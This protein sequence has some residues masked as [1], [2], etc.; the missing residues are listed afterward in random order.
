[1]SK[2]NPGLHKIKVNTWGTKDKTSNGLDNFVEQEL[3]GGNVGHASIEMMLPVTEETKKLIETYCKEETFEEFKAHLPLKAQQKLTFEQYMEQAEDRIP[4][5]LVET[6]VPLALYNDDGELEVSKKK[7]SQTSYYKIDF[8]FWPGEDGFYLSN[9]EEDMIDEREGHH[10]EYSERA[11]EYLQPEERIH[12]GKIGSQSMTYAPSVIAHQRN[13]SD[14]DFKE[15]ERATEAQKIKD[16]LSSSGL[17]IK[18]VKELKSLKIDGTLG[19]ICKNMGLQTAPIIKEFMEANPVQKGEKV[20]IEKFK[21]FFIEK[22]R[23]HISGLQRKR[24]ELK[25]HINK[26]GDVDEILGR[27]KHVTRG[28]PPDHTVELPFVTESSRGLN[29]EAMLK[30]MRELTNPDAAEF[31]LHTKNCSKTST[32]VLKAG[33]EH[34]PLLSRTLGEEALGAIGTPQQVIGNVERARNV[35]VTDKQNTLLTRIAN[36]DMLNQAM[37]GFI[38]E[39]MKEDLTRGQKAKAIAGIIGVGILKAPEALI[40]AVINPSQSM[41]DLASGVGTV[42]KHANSLPLKIG[43]GILSAIPMVFLAPF[44]LVEKGLQAMA[45]PFNA[46]SRW[47]D[48]KPLSSKLDDQITVPLASEYLEEGPKNSTYRSMMAG[49]V[50]AQVAKNIKENTVEASAKKTNAVDILVQFEI[51]LENNPDKVV[52]LS[53]KDFDTLNRYVREKNTP[54]LTSRFQECCDESVKRANK[55]SPHK[56]SEVDKIIDEVTP[57]ETQTSTVTLGR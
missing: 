14:E 27:Q 32:A 24:S 7:A 16:L 31:N 41:S 52:T 20:D 1:M 21:E 5:R 4:V 6:S 2:Y 8:S 36:S 15:I 57:E 3:F 22:A 54:Q 25:K 23:E 9:I 29:P 33:A 18:K 46:L 51:D 26:V 28:L 12:R 13:L 56:L 37:G 34:D 50:D 53:A 11:K 30:K 47:L 17:I 10:F 49:L 38:A 39:Y 55:L 40:R 43:A 35:I 45:A 19:L 44:A 48:K 42:F